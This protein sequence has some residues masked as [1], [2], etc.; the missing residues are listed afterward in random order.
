MLCAL[1]RG[2][3]KAWRNW[4]TLLAKHYCFCLKS[5]VTFLSIAND[6]ETNN[7]ACQA[8][9]AVCQGLRWQLAQIYVNWH[10]SFEIQIITLFSTHKA[11]T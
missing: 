6:L 8:V 2:R 10:G 4:P 11:G 9:L 1:A 5:G 3:L 7:S